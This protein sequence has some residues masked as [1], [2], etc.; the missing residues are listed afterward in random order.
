MDRLSSVFTRTFDVIVFGAGYAGYAA[1]N[2]LHNQ[3]KSVLLIHR[4]GAVLWESGWAFSLATGRSSAPEWLDFL[5]NLRAHNAASDAFI[6]GAIAEVLATHGLLKMQIPVLYYATPVAAHVENDRLTAIAVAIKEGLGT[7]RARQFIDASDGGELVALVAAAYVP[8]APTSQRINLFFRNTRWSQPD[9]VAATI[10]IDALPQARATWS[11]T[12]W[13]NQRV[14]CVDL[15]GNFPRH[16]AAWIP[17]LRGIHA[18]CP[19]DL[20]G[21]VLSHGS[22]IPLCAY[23]P[24][25]PPAIPAN[26]ALAIPGFSDTPITTLADRFALGLC[27][28][29][30]LDEMPQS[31]PEAFGPDFPQAAIHLR[32]I[33]TQ[34]AV[35]GTGT[36]GAC[37]AI[38][39]AR[40]G[41]HVTAIEP[42]PFAGGIGTGGGIHFYYFGVRGG[43]QEEIDQLTR[44][45]MPLFGKSAQIVGFHP[46][47][48]KIAVEQL[49][50]DAGVWL[51]PD[52]TLYAAEHHDGSIFRAL[53]ATPG[54]AVALTASAWI[55]ATGDGDLAA[56]AGASFTLGRAADGQLHAY[57]Q[58]SGRV[59]ILNQLPRMRIVNTDAGF[60]DPTNT[61]DLT[62]ARLA[63]VSHWY[64][65]TYDELE[66]PTYVAPALGVRQGRHIDTDY[67]LT[68]G[69]LINR[70]SFPDTVGYTGAHYDNHAVDYEFESDEA[71]FW[72]WV[73]RQWRT[74]IGCEIPYR[75]LLPVGLNNLWLACRA[76]G[77]SLEAHPAMRMQ[78][79]IQRLGEVAGYAA[80]LA[81][82]QGASSRTASYPRLRALLEKSGA[83][84]LDR[85]PEESFGVKIDANDVA[86]QRP[87]DLNDCL[88]ELQTTSGVALYHLY[89]HGIAAR[90][91][92]APLVSHADPA[93][94][95]RAAALLAMWSDPLAESRLLQAIRD[96]EYGFQS[97]PQ[98]QQ[99]E[100]NPQHVP[101]YIVATA[102]L[103][104]C[105]TPVALPDFAALAADPALP[106]NGRTALALA[107]VSM[108]QR[109]K[110][111][112]P[113]KALLS[114]ILAQLLATAAPNALRNPKRRL[115]APSDFAAPAPNQRPPVLED[116]TWQLH[117]A[118][119]KAES[120]AHLP[121]HPGAATFLHD[122]RAIV[123]K[124]FMSVLQQY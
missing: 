51:L 21:A 117:L 9:P 81:I 98:N 26:L 44:S 105:C 62:R 2:A 124:A 43:L 49:L 13:S 101:H 68:L 82:Q 87:V 42:L 106:H 118:I 119:A 110:L 8:P 59:E 55:D 76:A 61:E 90:P 102:L 14:L 73:C 39:A 121:I 38:A 93:I 71:M 116:C 31:S 94:S 89:R 27:A 83:L 1:A 60:V 88:A 95:F 85:A 16:R 6:D 74:Y 69:D 96:R 47:A 63:G 25:T 70:Q 57:S 53:I 23:D 104:R 107:L 64:Q 54:G 18:A 12:F 11:S 108:A 123:R 103:R 17:S 32:P 37:A 52:S 112:E 111:V 35:V 34:V 29:R 36:G 20:Q 28:A 65:A 84:T 109:H 99:P 5:E 97:T 91:L 100:N 46:D 30:M 122:P 19:D 66:R 3:G 72:V 10:L 56:H 48:K 77:V 113:Q 80:A 4:Q 58:P 92:V 33:S 86:P 7:L 79:D 41:I 24:T 115:A 75:M 40:Q 120:A 114:K 15:P 22:L 67:T 50:A 45:I 78:R